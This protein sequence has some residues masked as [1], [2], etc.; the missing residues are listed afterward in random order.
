MSSFRSIHA[1]LRAP[2][3]SSSSQARLTT[4][5][6]FLPSIRTY[7]HTPA[8][9]L[10]YK[11]DQDRQ[12]LKPQSS[13]GT[14]SGTDDAAA[15]SDAAFDGSKT[16]PEESRESVKKESNRKGENSSLESSGASHE[17][18]KPLGEEGGAEMKGTTRQESSKASGGGSPQKK[19]KGPAA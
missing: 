18:S 9:R 13:Q 11:D 14:V 4:T 6:Q 10:P 19:G 15:Q 3:S 1:L 12:S 8:A 17:K 7:H 16:A 2:S 5:R